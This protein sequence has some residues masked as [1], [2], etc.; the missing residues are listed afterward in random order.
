M[1]GEIPPETM[2]HLTPV[3]IASSTISV[4]QAIAA[5]HAGVWSVLALPCSDEELREH[6]RDGLQ[7]SQRRSQKRHKFHQLDDRFRQLDENEFQVLEMIVEGK[8]AKQ[9][10]LDLNI[11]SRTVDRRKQSLHEKT[12]SQSLADLMLSYLEWRMTHKNKLNPMN[13]VPPEA[14]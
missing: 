2:A 14:P 9:I 12:S 11:S 10:A 4:P 13:P 5:M 7:I 8:S 6:L 3:L 1:M